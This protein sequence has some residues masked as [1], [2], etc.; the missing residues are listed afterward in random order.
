MKQRLDIC[1]I[2]PH[3]FLPGEP[4]CVA[5]EL[6]QV[7]IRRVGVGTP[8]DSCL[9]SQ[10]CFVD[11]LIGV[12]ECVVRQLSI[13][14]VRRR[15]VHGTV[16]VAFATCASKFGG[17]NHAA[18]ARMR[19]LPPYVCTSAS[20]LFGAKRAIQS[21]RIKQEWT[22]LLPNSKCRSRRRTTGGENK[23]TVRQGKAR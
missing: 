4:L 20:A 18:V 21:K 2:M 22:F 9:A 7:R 1:P 16:H 3:L 19:W 14:S 12:V 10:V 5:P 6:G 11:V 13:R 15:G 17:L 23:N 8:A